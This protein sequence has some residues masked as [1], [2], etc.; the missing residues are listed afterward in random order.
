MPGFAEQVGT[1]TDYIIHPEE[2][3]ADN[4]VFLINGRVD[5][6]S[7][8]VVQEMGRILQEAGAAP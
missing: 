3:L 2:I 4:F 7:Q 6:P 5:L 8:R 1:N